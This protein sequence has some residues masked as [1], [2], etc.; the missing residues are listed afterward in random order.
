MNV[1]EIEISTLYDAPGIR[2]GVQALNVMRSNFSGENWKSVKGIPV[3]LH[4]ALLGK[5]IGGGIAY[6]EAVCNTN[7]GF[8]IR[9]VEA[10]VIQFVPP[11]HGH[12]NFFA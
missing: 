6:G 9:Y 10:K 8:G 5:N 11:Y 12:A 2:N 4:H 1:V 3:D 7:I